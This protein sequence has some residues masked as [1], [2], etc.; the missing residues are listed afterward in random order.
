MSLAN[1]L[2]RFMA[3]WICSY[4]HAIRHSPFG[5]H[6]LR[7]GRHAAAIAVGI[8]GGIQRVGRARRRSGAAE[9]SSSPP[10]ASD[11]P[12]EPLAEPKPTT[13]VVG[14]VFERRGRWRCCERRRW[15]GGRLCGLRFRLRGL[16]EHVREQI[17]HVINL[18][19][20]VRRSPPNQHPETTTPEDMAIWRDNEGRIRTH[21]RACVRESHTRRRALGA[22]RRAR[23]RTH[24]AVGFDCC[25]RFD[26]V[27]PAAAP[28]GPRRRWFGRRS[29]FPAEPSPPPAEVHVE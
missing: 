26:R 17:V 29:L 5:C 25:R 20:A 15:F 12:P 23:A 28:A 2:G 27:A 4:S 19:P 14:A 10:A 11:A 21:T 24:R 13:A 8:V 6:G 7:L 18:P 3:S 22:L 1:V 16:I 9:S